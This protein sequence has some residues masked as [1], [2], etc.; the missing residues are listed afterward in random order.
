M[1]ASEQGIVESEAELNEKKRIEFEN[2]LQEQRAERE[3]QKAKKIQNTEQNKDPKE[4][5]LVIQKNFREKHDTLSKNVELFKE[6]DNLDKLFEDLND[7]NE[8]FVN[9]SYSL[10]PYDRQLYKDQLDKLRN[11]LQECRDRSQPKKKF[12]FSKKIEKKKEPETKTEA[13]VAQEDTT[14]NDALTLIKGI[15][16]KKGETLTLTQADL[17]ASFKL[18]NLEDCTISLNGKLK[19]LFLKQLKNCVINIGVIDGSCFIDGC[20]GCKV[21]FVA[22]QARIHNSTETTFRLFVTSKPIIEHCT[23]LQFGQYNYTYE[24]Y[25]HDF[26]ESKF[27]GKENLW[28]QVQDFNWHKQDKSP[29]FDLI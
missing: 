4:M 28:D 2:L 29:N 1:N 21:Q 17:E 5:M 23:K 14:Q 8:Y 16:N 3:T 24:N 11:S 18:A 27:A 20:V 9:A 15:E 7:L 6:G 25:D 19:N 13:P 12:A 10:T 22:Q 26:A